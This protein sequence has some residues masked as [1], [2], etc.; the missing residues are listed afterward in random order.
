MSVFNSFVCL[1]IAFVLVF[2]GI[3]GVFV[4]FYFMVGHGVSPGTS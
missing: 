2:I 3:G 1:G 4:V